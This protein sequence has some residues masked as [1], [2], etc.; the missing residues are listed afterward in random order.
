MQ[1]NEESQVCGRVAGIFLDGLLASGER[2]WLHDERLWSMLAVWSALSV[3]LLKHVQFV[4]GNAS[5]KT[6]ARGMTTCIHTHNLFVPGS[7]D[8]FTI[9]F[10]QSA[11][12]SCFVFKKFHTFPV[13]RI[14]MWQTTST[15]ARWLMNLRIWCLN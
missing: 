4:C 9:A 14:M 8:G 7:S 12:F 5:C 11:F 1:C 15:I 13:C 2:W 6:P 10:D 3:F